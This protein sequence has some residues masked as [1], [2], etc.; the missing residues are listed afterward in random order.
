MEISRYLGS[1]K[2][3]VKWQ[4]SLTVCLV[5]VQHLGDAC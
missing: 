5:A 2:N 1:H 3:R 4:L